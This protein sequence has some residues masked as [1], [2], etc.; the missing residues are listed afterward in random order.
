VELLTAGKRRLEVRWIP[1]R[2][3]DLPPL[4]FLHEALGSAGLWRDFPDRVAE[5][6]GAAALITLAADTAGRS[7]S[8]L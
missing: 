8:P 1:P 3:T 2:R 7:R 5:R 4:V 6:T